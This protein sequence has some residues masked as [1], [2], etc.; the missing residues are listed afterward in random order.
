MADSDLELQLRVF[1]IDRIANVA[2]TAIRFGSAV[3]KAAFA[4]LCVRSF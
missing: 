3:A 2:E 1:K 4:W